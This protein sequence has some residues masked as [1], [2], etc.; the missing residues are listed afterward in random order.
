[1]SFYFWSF[2]VMRNNLCLDKNSMSLAVNRRFSIISYFFFYF[3]SFKSLFP[4][5]FFDREFK[6]RKFFCRKHNIWIR[7]NANI[8]NNIIFIFLQQRFLC[9][10][11][12]SLNILDF[13][14]RIRSDISQ[15]TLPCFVLGQLSIFRTIFRPRFSPKTWI[16]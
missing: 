5:V 9:R 10:E 12:V 4:A 15:E 6:R 3:I 1:L 13:F 8:W 16:F 7:L 2:I 14:L 11:Q